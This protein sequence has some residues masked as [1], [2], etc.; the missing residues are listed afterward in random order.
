MSQHRRSVGPG[1]PWRRGRT[2]VVAGLAAV[3]VAGGGA[4]A[5]H[6]RANARADESYTHPASVA[7]VQLPGTAPTAAAAPVPA[8]RLQAGADRTATAA[9]TSYLRARADGDVATSYALLDAGSRRIYPTAARWLDAQPDLAAPSTFRVLSSATAGARVDVSVDVRRTAVLDPFVGFRPAHAVEVYR[10]V[11]TGSAWRVQALPV[12][13]SPRLIADTAAPAAVTA[14]LDRLRACD[15]P[16]AGRFQSAAELV[17]DDSLPAALC[18]APAGLRV[19]PP[20]PLTDQPETAAF[21]AAYGPELGSYARLVPVT[22]P[23]P[24]LLVGVAPLG[25]AWRVFGIVRG[26]VG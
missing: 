24:S 12:R 26:G 14:W 18:S 20:Q 3:A 16:G 7:S 11:R 10:A 19:G 22:G 8:A 4:T 23:G 17:G 13:V 6:M 1:A 25:S 5:L 21:V 2:A 9:V 15:I